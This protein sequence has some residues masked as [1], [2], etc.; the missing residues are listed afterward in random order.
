MATWVDAS[1]PIDPGDNVR[2]ADAARKMSQVS[3][4]M[5]QFALLGLPGEP[6]IEAVYAL[7]GSGLEKV[8]HPG[9]H[10]GSEVASLAGI[11]IRGEF[12]QLRA[13]PFDEGPHARRE[14]KGMGVDQLDGQ[15]QGLEIPE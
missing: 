15:V 13:S 4:C 9:Q 1:S 14:L 12:F 10:L 7:C 2:H 5:G 11:G 6:G 8:F 3:N